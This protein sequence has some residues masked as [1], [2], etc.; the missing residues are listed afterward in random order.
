VGGF[1]AA[2]HV[3]KLG[4]VSDVRAIQGYVLI[5]RG[6]ERIWLDADLSQKI[7][8]AAPEA[9]NS[10]EFQPWRVPRWAWYACAALAA[11]FAAVL[12]SR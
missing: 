3:W 6:E 9:K 4:Q 2:T 10:A 12:F 11:L 1:K 5:R 8:E 7:G